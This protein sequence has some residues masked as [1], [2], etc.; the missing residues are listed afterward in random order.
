MVKES[1]TGSRPGY[2]DIDLGRLLGVLLDNKWLIMLVTALFAVAAVIHVQLATP[3]YRADALVQ[4]EGKT[5]LS[6]P[7]A[8][9]RSFLGD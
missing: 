7:L 8:E 5:G 4:V 9:V 2:D 1:K 6:N 3:I